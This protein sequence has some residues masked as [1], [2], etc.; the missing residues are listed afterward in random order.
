M[1]ASALEE[2]L[3]VGDGEDDRSAAEAFGCHF[4]GVVP[5]VPESASRCRP[6]HRIDDLSGLAGGRS[7]SRGGAVIGDKRVLAV[8]PARGGSKG[9]PLKNLKP[10][11]GVPLVA[12]VGHLVREIPIIDRAVVSTDHDEI[13]R[14]AEES[15]LAAPVPAARGSLRRPHLGPGGA[16]ATP[17]TRWSGS[18]AS[19]T[20]SW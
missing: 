20:T 12:R 17:C 16:D 1:P 15:G 14:V 10:F 3:F 2:L 7:D 13:A 8:C 5:A 18:T 6:A 19:T 9:I 11:L 4:A